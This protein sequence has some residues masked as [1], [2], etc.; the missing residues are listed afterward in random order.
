MSAATSDGDRLLVVTADSHVGP[1]VRDLRE[2]CESRYLDEYDTFVRTFE[3]QARNRTGES[4]DSRLL[5]NSTYKRYG[6]SDD[7]IAAAYAEAQAGPLRNAKSRG[8]FDVDS[9]LA[10]MDY[11]GVAAEVVLHGT[12]NAN[13]IIE[14]FPFGIH[15]HAAG[16]Q[17]R[18]LVAA[19]IDMYNRWLVDFCSTAPE[20]H[21]GMCYAPMWDPERAAAVVEWGANHGLRGVNFP[22]ASAAVLPYEDPAWDRLFALCADRGLPLCTHLGTAL[23]PNYW[24]PAAF[25]ILIYEAEGIG[26]RNVWHLILS[27]T[28]D[29]HPELKLIV[30]EV[31]GTWFCDAPWR[32]DDV[33]DDPCKGGP[34]LRRFLKKR[35]SEYIYS[36]VYFGVSFMSR[37]EAEQTVEQGLVDRVMWGSDYPHSEG[38]WMYF[39]D[40]DPSK[41]SVT[42]LALANTLHGLGEENI[43]KMAGLNAA[44]CFGLDARRL[45]PVVDRIGPSLAEINRRPDLGEVPADY[46]G[47]GFREAGH[48]ASSGVQR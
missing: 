38:T 34:A 9:R 10:D 17:D 37:Y 46:V 23:P 33:Y 29:R 4:N 11:D 41:T 43:R 40:D 7:D 31:A 20:R 36:N 48:A 13:G 30:T 3:E 35:P 5:P 15:G 8:S 24:G 42:R 44:E 21:A 47:R 25:G 45:A 32:L 18:E 14:P 22:T 16:Q 39:D 19:G 6:F 28:F 12:Q 27:G 2:Y 26:G 1:S